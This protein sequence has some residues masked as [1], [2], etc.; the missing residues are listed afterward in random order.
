MRRARDRRSGGPCLRHRDAPAA[1]HGCR[2]RHQRDGHHRDRPRDGPDRRR[3]GPQRGER[4]SLRPTGDRPG[5]NRRPQKDVRSDRRAP[6]RTTGPR[7]RWNAARHARRTR[8]WRAGPRNRPCAAAN[9]HARRPTDRLRSRHRADRSGRHGVHPSTG[10]PGSHRR[11]VVTAHLGL[12][13]RSIDRHHPVGCSRSRWIDGRSRACGRR[14]AR[15]PPGGVETREKHRGEPST[16]TVRIDDSP[17]RKD[18]RR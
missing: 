7:N 2:S 12:H 8:R 11:N 1:R 4:R 15:G 9:R 10:G 14:P 13:Q 6:R 5:R 16:A 18:V 17:Q 3:A